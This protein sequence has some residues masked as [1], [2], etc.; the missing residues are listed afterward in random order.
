[1]TTATAK[2]LRDTEATTSTAKERNCL[3]CRE[4]FMSEWAGERICSRCK[5][6]STWKNGT[7]HTSSF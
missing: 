4:V 7:P 2:D 5:K 6:S 3:R 1:M